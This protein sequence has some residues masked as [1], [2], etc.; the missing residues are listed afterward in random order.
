MSFWYPDV[1]REEMNK[2]EEKLH[3]VSKEK[4]DRTHTV[5]VDVKHFRSY[6]NFLCRSMPDAFWEILL[7]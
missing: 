6:Q 5:S 7:F 4:G 1:Q 2:E 3:I